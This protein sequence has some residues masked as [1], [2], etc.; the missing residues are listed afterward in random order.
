LRVV[1]PK[2]CA[3]NHASIMADTPGFK[4]PAHLVSSRLASI[5]SVW[6]E[7]ASGRIC[8]SRAD[9]TPARLRGALP[10]SWMMD[11]IDD[12]N[13]YRFRFAGEQI[14]QFMGGRLAG[15]LVSSFRGRPFFDGMHA[16][17][18]A[19][20]RAKGPIIAGPMQARHEGK[21][22]LEIEVIALPLSDDG[23]S[24]ANLLGGIDTWPLGTHLS[25][26]R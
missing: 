9:V 13:D 2:S 25:T 3:L 23:N 7:L 10:W 6:Q 21:E 1:S 26:T 15:S 20:A 16:M 24:V 5:H 14:V 19:C 8:P 4:D 17:F 18:T 12:G 22:F 11:V